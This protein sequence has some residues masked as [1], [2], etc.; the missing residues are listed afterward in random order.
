MLLPARP[1]GSDHGHALRRAMGAL[2]FGCHGG[3]C[4]YVALPRHSGI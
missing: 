4:I 1:L 3:P 2:R